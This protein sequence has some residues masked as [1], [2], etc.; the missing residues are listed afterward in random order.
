MAD[1]R[2]DPDPSFRRAGRSTVITDG[3]GTAVLRIQGI[4][5]VYDVSYRDLDSD[6]SRLTS[7]S[8]TNDNT[9]GIAVFL[10]SDLGSGPAGTAPCPPAPGS[11][12]GVIDAADVAALP[13]QGVE[14]R[15]V[16][17]T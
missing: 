10:C 14:P 8:A 11:S 15:A 6:I 4:S 5:V 3:R 9:G 17:V 1:S 7:T 16:S 13:L 12:T 2:P